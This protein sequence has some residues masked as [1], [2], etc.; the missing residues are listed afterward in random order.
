MSS[1]WNAGP[2]LSL[3]I[4]NGGRLRS[5]FGAASASYDEAVDGYNQTIVNALKDISDEVVHLRSLQTQQDDAQRSV[6]IAQRNDDLAKK[7]YTRGL[8]DYVNVLIAQTQLLRAQESLAK[9][10]A[11]RLAN[12]ASLA[13]ALGGGLAQPSD[14]PSADQRLPKA[15]LHPFGAGDTETPVTTGTNP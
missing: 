6:S 9:V 14:G 12:R 7:G 1:G 4:L 5:Q 13:V 8:T 2:A 10:Q 11:E 15:S 3:P